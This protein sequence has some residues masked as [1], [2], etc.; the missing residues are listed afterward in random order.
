MASSM[1]VEKV[2]AEKGKESKEKF[3][4]ESDNMYE[5]DPS[6][7]AK[8]IIVNVL[9]R[10]CTMMKSE[11]NTTVCMKQG[12]RLQGQYYVD[13]V[14]KHRVSGLQLVCCLEEWFLK[15][16][17]ETRSKRHGVV[18]QEWEKEAHKN[19]DKT[20]KA[21]P[22]ERRVIGRRSQRRKANS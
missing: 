22:L 16:L 12:D 20:V 4:E 19:I 17:E 13:L 11:G 18:M 7:V 5:V 15:E 1:V 14:K 21:E 6:K 3:I 9:T 2:K 8:D 10:P